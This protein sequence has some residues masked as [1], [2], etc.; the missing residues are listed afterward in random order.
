[1]SGL[2]N[3]YR[4]RATVAIMTVRTHGHQAV[5]AV[6]IGVVVLAYGPSLGGG[7]VWDDHAI[8]EAN[9]AL[10]API[11]LW[12]ESLFGP[13]GGSG[14]VFR[15]LVM[16]TFLP[17]HVL[18]LGPMFE[19][20]VSLALHLG[21]V[22]LLA[23]VVEGLGERPAAAWLVAALFG[24]HP[25]VS[26]VV[27]WISGRQDLL[28]GLLAVGA[29]AAVVRGRPWVA[30]ALLVP[31][32]FCKESFV[33][34]GP[35]MF[36]W[37]M[38][39]KKMHPAVLLPMV[40]AGVYMALRSTVGLGVDGGLAMEPVAALGALVARLPVLAL[41]PD[42]ARTFP[43]YAP[44]VML[45][46]IGLT[47]GVGLLI[48]SWGRPR[49]AAAT[50]M[51][52]FALPGALAAAHTGLMSDRYLHL[53]VLA[54][55]LLGSMVLRSRTVPKAAWALPVVLAAVTGVRA[56]AWTSDARLFEAA[57]ARDPDNARAAFHLGHARHRHEGDCEA[58]IPL[59]E[60]GLT[61]DPRAGTNL[62]ACL[63]D[64]D[65]PGE[66]LEWTPVA[67]A[68]QP[69]NPNP[70]ANG[71]RAAVAVGDLASAERW[72]R[73]ALERAPDRARNLVLLGNIL[74]QG[75]RCE[76]ALPVFQAAV[77]SDPEEPGG[78]AGLAACRRQL[79][80]PVPQP[81]TAG[82]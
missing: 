40:G 64:L 38:G 36:V 22:F 33:L 35:V 66:A 46:C 60:R 20:I 8:V 67:V 52:V 76:E 54:V 24:V 42:G 39:R 34:A 29:L 14:N 10:A 80:G 65:R 81:G 21:T 61:A 62:Q 71:A 7:W 45:G 16:M 69:T 79:A 72:A 1:M 68:A 53:G 82:G 73:V 56:Q 31:T 9:P 2:P 74:G 47:L 19:R 55:V 78:K 13:S 32:P 48:A 11:R 25:G 17:G 43:A 26:E 4:A 3:R 58:A 30:G 51:L 70:A 27:A 28:P 49:I 12:S 44:S 23:R 50:G 57:L 63:L 77:D 6:A 18:G 37:M 59:Y 41:W 75:G 5:L 15:P